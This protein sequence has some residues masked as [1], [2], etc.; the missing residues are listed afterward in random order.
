M[1]KQTL[2]GRNHIFEQKFAEQLIVGII[3]IWAPS[4][5]IPVLCRL[6]LLLFVPY[7]ALNDKAQHMSSAVNIHIRSQCSFQLIHNLPGH[8]NPKQLVLSFFTTVS[9][10]WHGYCRRYTIWRFLFTHVV[11]GKSFDVFQVFSLNFRM[12]DRSKWICHLR[13]PLKFWEKSISPICFSREYPGIL[14]T[15]H[16]GINKIFLVLQ[17]PMVQKWQ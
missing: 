9:S 10:A 15:T 7:V 14:N 17:I 13:N 2:P 4:V 8:H 1:T 12:G 16:V 3:V 5:L 6:S 11:P